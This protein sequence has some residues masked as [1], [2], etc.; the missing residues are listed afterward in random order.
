MLLIFNIIWVSL[1]ERRESVPS[2][3]SVFFISIAYNILHFHDLGWVAYHEPLFYSVAIAIF[4]FVTDELLHAAIL[5]S[6]I[7]VA[8]LIIPTYMLGKELFGRKVGLLSAILV[9][10]M[11][12]VRVIAHSP[13]SEALY[14][15]LLTSSVYLLWLAYKK[16]SVSL[17]ILT[18]ISFAFAYLTRS[19]GVFILCFLSFILI[20]LEAKK[21]S[22]N[23]RLII[24]LAL[25][26]VTFF[27]SSLPYLLFLRNHYGT[28]VLGTKTSGIYF[29]VRE[30]SFRDPDPERLEWGLSPKGE[31]NLI[32]MTSRDLIEYWLKDPAK[33]IKVYLINLKGHIPGFIPNTSSQSH[34]PQVYPVYLAIPLLLGLLIRARRR[35]EMDGDLYLL[36]VFSVLFIYPLFTEG[37]A[38]YLVNYFPIFAI[39]SASG[40]N[41]IND[42]FIRH[43]KKENLWGKMI[44]RDLL[45]WLL[46]IIISIYH[47][48]VLLGKRLPEDMKRY[49]D[50][51]YAMALE[52]KKAG[53]WA[54]KRFPT[55]SNYMVDW[56][57]LPYYLNG[58]WTAKPVTTYNRMIWYA[59]RNKVDYIVYETYGRVESEGIV[60]GL[61]NTPDLE[62]AD[63]Y[64]S[65]TSSYGV[66][67]LKLRK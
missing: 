8:L 23:K 60:R 17:S 41:E 59:R 66:V 10:V 51:K 43:A 52:T 5:V 67:F 3:D 7:S 45:L 57:R 54:Q 12:H 38:R 27:I 61:G 2:A 44:S 65:A 49:N 18:G 26:I 21:R 53:E 11:P 31:I 48:W 64:E 40:L 32:S 33:S 37:W 20:I 58:R 16:Q 28:W 50:M 47:T 55:G 22:L 34:F 62:V 14:T 46:V 24:S 42:I 36:P 35:D 56:T 13:E 39:L 30:R 15:L 63:V 19:E 9:M 4:S 1:P 29:W 6:K 25:V